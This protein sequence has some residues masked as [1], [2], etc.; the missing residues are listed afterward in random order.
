MHPRML[1]RLL[2]FRI[3]DSCSDTLPNAAARSPSN[4]AVST[5]K[6]GLTASERPV[7][8]VE[9]SVLHQQ[10]SLNVSRSAGARFP[11]RDSLKPLVSEPS[12]IFG[13]NTVSDPGPLS[14][15]SPLRRLTTE[16]LP[17]DGAPSS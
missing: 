4:A 7:R 17:V 10:R 12:V 3:G 5:P 15:E 6:T 8:S 1:K 13:A 11:V 2:R 16:V 14:L 9:N